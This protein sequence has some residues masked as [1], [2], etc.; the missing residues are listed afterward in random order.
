MIYLKQHKVGEDN[1]KESGYYKT[2]LDTDIFFS[3]E[4]GWDYQNESDSGPQRHYPK[5]W[6]SEVT[7]RLYSQEEIIKLL[8]S[9]KENE[10]PDAEE[11]YHFQR[12]IWSGMQRF[13]EW[14]KMIKQN[15]DSQLNKDKDK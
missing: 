4:D 11:P 1:P 8:N 14:F 9:Y 3:I 13:I 5:F 2:D 12:E 6:Y 10:L 7:E 15:K